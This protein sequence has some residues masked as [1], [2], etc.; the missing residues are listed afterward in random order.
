MH[1]TVPY[2]LR[3]A[4]VRDELLALKAQGQEITQTLQ[5]PLVCFTGDTMWGPH[6]EREDVLKA[7]ILITEC[8]FLEPGH[9]NRANV[10]K[11]LH[12]DHVAKLL[13]RSE[14]EAVVLTHLSRRTHITQVRKQ[15]EASIPRALQ[16]RLF[17]LM[18]G[19][20]NRRRYEDQLAEAGE[21]D[22]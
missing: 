13:E 14:A 8:T 20:T 6:F 3:Q 7:K 22:G 19:R 21:T 17:V 12:L 1:R 5:I 11:H 9:R 18:D 10:G 4:P 16:D 2:Q 15:L